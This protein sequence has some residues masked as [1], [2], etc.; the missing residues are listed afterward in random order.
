MAGERAGQL[1][2][3][4][5]R[6]VADAL[7]LAGALD[8]AAAAEIMAG[9]EIALIA[10]SRLG[11]G[12]M[13]FPDFWPGLAAEQAPAG[14]YLAV[15]AG[16]SR[17]AA[18]T[19]GLGDTEI[20]ALVIAPDRTIMTAAGQAGAGL[21][22]LQATGSM[23]TFPFDGE[24][25][26]ADD[27]GASYRLRMNSCSWDDAGEWSGI[28]QVTPTPA[29]GGRWLDLRLGDA[30]VPVRISLPRSP[31]P[32]PAGTRP[33]GEPAGDESGAEL[34]P[35]PGPSRWLLDRCA[36]SMLAGAFE[37]GPAAG[38]RG[39]ADIADVADALAAAGALEP[40]QEALDRLVALAR[41]LGVPVPAGLAGRAVAAA[42][43]PAAWED[44]LAGRESPGPAGRAAA[45]CAGV[46]P[47]LAGTQH[48][49]AGL[50]STPDGTAL[51]TASWGNPP[52][53]PLADWHDEAHWS[54]WARDDGGHWHVGSYGS[55]GSSDGFAHSEVRLWPPVPAA[56][57][58]LRVYLTAPEGRVSAIIPLAWQEQQ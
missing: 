36:E 31:G 51:R 14:S 27:L 55:G 24:I 8:E 34:A 15:P 29:A 11:P 37:T 2:L 49:T 9:L 50:S 26:A 20:F 21:A 48:V 54:W 19:A 25:T 28:L 17:A 30:A 10:R 57:T 41:R 23:R 32:P 13:R 6:S 3:A 53:R 43:L 1:G 4:R 33:G 38:R 52:P 42:R 56:A 46:L 40:A 47:P 18:S 35:P 12:R 58:A 7:C 39:L 22:G 16:V 44:V 45:G 5:L